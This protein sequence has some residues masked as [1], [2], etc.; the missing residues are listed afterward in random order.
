M[1]DKKCLLWYNHS[2]ALLFVHDIACAIN[3][4]YAE[5]T[6][7]IRLGFASIC[8]VIVCKWMDRGEDRWANRFVSVS[9]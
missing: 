7:K 6:V 5:V 2:F 1:L 9:Q 8:M 4:C 3:R